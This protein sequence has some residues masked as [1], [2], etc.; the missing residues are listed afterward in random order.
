[1]R[2]ITVRQPYAQ[3]IAMGLKGAENRTRALLMESQI[4]AIHASRRLHEAPEQAFACCSALEKADLPLGAII[5]LV[6]I[7]P[8]RA[9]I[10]GA[11]WETGPIV[12]PLTD[13]RM[14]KRPIPCAGRVGVWTVPPDVEAAVW[15]AL[16]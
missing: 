1:M 2:A 16:D 9:A 13:A 15:A 5:A 11:E 6:R 4:V 12:H 7:G 8:P 3:A 14:L 10:E